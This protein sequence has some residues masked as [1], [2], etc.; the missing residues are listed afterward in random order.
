MPPR[1]KTYI[2]RFHEKYTVD[3]VSQCWQWRGVIAARYG[4]LTVDGKP[5]RAHRVSWEIHRGAIPNGL[6]VC[7]RCDVPTCVN[8]CHL[9]LG[10]A[11]DN[12]Q[13]A[14]AKNRAFDVG[15]ANRNKT[16]CPRGHA[17]SE[18]NIYIVNNGKSRACKICSS[19]SSKL[20]YLANRKRSQPS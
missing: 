19:S 18:D 16:H 11:R 8:P 17:Y 13:D 9:F 20:R 2:Q 1:R 5:R 10:T 14:A 12:N 4:Y 7:H 6:Y 15:R 3:P